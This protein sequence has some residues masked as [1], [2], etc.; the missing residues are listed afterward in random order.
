[1][2]AAHRRCSRRELLD[3]C[4]RDRLA[5]GNDRERLERRCAESSRFRRRKKLAHPL[6]VFRVGSQL[7]ALRLFANLK[8]PLLFD[9]LDFQL[10]QCGGNFCLAYPRKLIGENSSSAPASLIASVSS[11]TESGFCA[12][13]RSA[14]I[15]RDKVM[16]YKSYAPIALC[17]ASAIWSAFC[18][19]IELATFN[20]QTNFWLGTN[21][22][23]ARDLCPRA[24]SQLR[25]PASSPCSTRREDAFLSR[26]NSVGPADIFPDTPSVDSTVVRS[27]A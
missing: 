4:A 23:G 26:S 6:G 10:L 25:S 20:E 9:T 17:I 19:S 18:R 5:I 15:T 27:C 11:R 13:N 7:P 8:C 16:S 1:M 22:A 3:I 21:N 2:F 14:S 24:L 12:L